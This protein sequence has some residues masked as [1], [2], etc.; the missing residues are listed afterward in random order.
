MKSVTKS[1]LAILLASLALAFHPNA[2]AQQPSAATATNTT[3]APT[4]GSSLTLA[5]L[6]DELKKRGADIK[7]EGDAPDG[8][9]TSVIFPYSHTPRVMPDGTKVPPYPVTDDLVHQISKLPKVTALEFNMSD[10]L[11][12]AAIKDIGGM[13]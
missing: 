3:S 2:R 11:T 7:T 9:V 8:A 13:K 10:G 12:A 5:Q 1:F 6:V 4:P